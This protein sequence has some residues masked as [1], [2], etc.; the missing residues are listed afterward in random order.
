MTEPF[1]AFGLTLAAVWG[2]IWI[3][4]AGHY[5]AGRQIV[6]VDAV[7]IRFVAP[8]FPRYVALR[9]PDVD[10]WVAP[11]DLARYEEVYRAY[12]A[13]GDHRERFFAAGDIVQIG[14]VVPL[15]LASGLLLSPAVGI[16]LLLVSLLTTGAY[17]A[18]DAV[19]TRLRGD[20]SG[21]YSALWATT[22]RLPIFLLVG[23][24]SIHLSVLFLLG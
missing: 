24:V 8:Y 2:V 20:P 7:D 19:A 22:P 21:D 15:A 6:G 16:A 9:N 11:T 3:H 1:L 17:V 10:E 4:E 18:L 5:V 13:D 12:D 14:V 23:F